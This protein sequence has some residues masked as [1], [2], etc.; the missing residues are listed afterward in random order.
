M[1]FNQYKLVH[2]EDL[3]PILL[4]FLSEAGFDSFQETKVGLLAFGAAEKH[5]TWLKVLSELKAQFAFTFSSEALEEKNWNEEWER[6]F[7]PINIG[8]RLRIR[9][10][11]HDPDLSVER[12]LI[13]TPKM[14]FGTGH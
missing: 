11:F 1:K 5:D 6:Q 12:E 13:I 4:A 2:A 3:T 7:T 9:A 10:D 8:N 14:A